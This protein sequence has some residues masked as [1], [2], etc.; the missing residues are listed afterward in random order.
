MDSVR[1]REESNSSKTIIIVSLFQQKE[2]GS[3][4]KFIYLCKGNPEIG[5]ST[6]HFCTEVHK[7]E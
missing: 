6:F 1:Q 4:K 2:N 3:P 7:Y 5:F